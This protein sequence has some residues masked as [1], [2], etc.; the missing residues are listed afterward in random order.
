VTGSRV[1]LADPRSRALIGALQ[2]GVWVVDADGRITE[3]NNRFCEITG[4]AAEELIGSLPPRCYWPEEEHEHIQ[5]ALDVSQTGRSGHYEQ[6]WKRKD[7]ERFPVTVDASPLGSGEPSG[8]L[9]VVRDVSRETHERER[10]R[11]AHDVARLATWE[12]DPATDAIE[13]ST[14]LVDLARVELTGPTTLEQ[15]LA[16]V[17]AP[18]DQRI[19]ETFARLLGGAE[20]EAMLECRWDVPNPEIEW[21]E[22]RARP[23]R[24]FEGGHVIR[25]R[26]TT[27]DVTAR[28]LAELAHQ[29]SE[30]RLL[31]AQR[32]A[33]IGSFEIDYRTGRLTCSEHLYRL[34]GVEPQG[35]SHTLEE[36]RTMVPEPDRSTLRR[37]AGMTLEDGKPRQLQHRYGREEH[38]GWAETRIEP[39]AAD[40]QIYGVRGTMQDIT[41]RRRSERQIHLQGHLLDAVDA[42][43][44]A[45]DLDGAITYWSSG[46]ERTYGWTGEEALGRGPAD[47]GFAAQDEQAAASL[48]ETVY[49]VGQWEG[50]LEVGRKDGSRFPSYVRMALFHDLDGEPAGVVTMSVDIS[51]RLEGERQLRAARD[52]LRAI[53]ESMGEGLFTLDVEGR[54][55]YLNRAGERLLG[56]RREELAGEVMHDKVAGEPDDVFIRKDGSELPVEVTSAPFETEDGVRG[57]VVVFSDITER[58]AEERRMR[59]EIEE[60]SWIG[61]V[62]DALAE[63]RFVLYAQPIVDVRSGRTV[64]HELL[65]RMV[66]PEGNIVLPGE[67]LPSAERYGMITDIDRWVARQAIALAAAGH[68]VELNLSARSISEPGLVGDFARELERTGADPALIVVELTETAL[69]ED[70]QAAALFIERMGALGCQLALDDFGTG[71]GGFRY[72]K[73]LPVDY[74]KIDRDF[75]R[76]LPTN[77]A[78]QHVVKAVVSLAHGF[79]QQTV[80]EGV[81]DMETLRLLADYGVDLAQGY[82][83]ARPMPASQV[84]GAPGGGGLLAP[85]AARR[86]V[87]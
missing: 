25:L 30:E 51:E 31:Q 55:M 19:R 8:Y 56:W 13:L 33:D 9:C 46:A 32:M 49:E 41:E 53:T 84:L 59:R 23:V 80:A 71:Y 29:R 14:G 68:P 22:V 58:R 40:G 4:F 15:V 20:D 82:A 50:E 7:G 81:E 26:G 66:D 38:A 64:Q 63:D 24:D 61:Q 67:F 87:H 17:P 44:M 2:D 45:I 57:S 3:V 48:V 36:A 62:R 16:F 1:P 73:R 54:L 34:F 11:E 60:V 37:V 69:V 72:L 47:L 86:P 70:E 42:A 5:A 75:V 39:L 43:V 83:I 6:I 27:Q 35:F 85:A 65:L 18:N 52:Y 76:D 74:L 28:K 77:D 79:G 12:W 21:V 78:S 10:L